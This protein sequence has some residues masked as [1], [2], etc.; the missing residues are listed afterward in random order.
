MLLCRPLCRDR[1]LE[2]L[3][4]VN[5]MVHSSAFVDE[6]DSNERTDSRWQQE[7]KTLF[8]LVSRRWAMRAA[9]MPTKARKCSALRS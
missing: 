5:D 9:A 8:H 2:P 7:Y 3:C 6:A 4:S 1:Q